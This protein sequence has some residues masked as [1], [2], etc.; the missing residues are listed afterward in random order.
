MFE[1]IPSL[2]SDDYDA[3][4]LS[5]IVV[6]FILS[7]FFASVETALTTLSRFQI[8]Q[9]IEQGGFFKSSLRDWVKHPNRILAT[10]LVADTL[11]DTATATMT[12]YY[13]EKNYPGVSVVTVT[14]VLAVMVLLFGEILPKMIAR[15]YAVQL[16]PVACRVLLAVDYFLYPVTWTISNFLSRLMRAVGLRSERAEAVKSGDIEAMV[17][18]ATKEG[19]VERDKTTILSS[20][21]QFS[22]RRVKDI[23][24]PRDRISSISID[25]TL[26]QVLDIVRNENHSRYPVYSGSLDRIVGFLHARDLFSILRAGMN[27]DGSFRAIQTF[28]LRTC[29]RRA[30]FVSEAMMISRVLN[31]M[32]SSRIHLA[33]VKDE[34]GNVVGLVTLEDILEEVFGEIEDEHDDQVSKPV[35]DMFGAGIEVDGGELIVDLQSK[36]GVELETSESYSTL[37]GFLQHYAS[38]QVLTPKTVIIWKHY[39][40]SILSVRD[41]EIEKVRITEI[42]QTE[43][44]EEQR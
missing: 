6:S 32:K 23:M 12:A 22:K 31:E 3:L 5:T 15:T 29:L 44:S 16:G 26:T 34:W 40:F 43:D 13:M 41:G 11:C 28:S 7:T 39:V 38:H 4:L 27:Q 1:A 19:S 24:I 8:D 25:A 36:Y 20:V 14:I 42:P 21:F 17:E 35:I 37:N 30:F 18:L 9:L 33:I 10:I 2:I